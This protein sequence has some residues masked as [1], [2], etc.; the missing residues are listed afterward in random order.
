MSEERTEMSG[1]TLG[2]VLAVALVGVGLIVAIVTTQEESDPVDEAYQQGVDEWFEKRE[3][4]KAVTLAQPKPRELTPT[5]RLYL[6]V[7]A[8]Y[9]EQY[10]IVQRRGDPYEAANT[11]SLIAEGYLQM[12][13]E[14]KYNYWRDVADGHVAEAERQMAEKIGL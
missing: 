13:N 11:A 7:V 6:P 8:Q 1:K 5:E 12:K 4:E 2:I 3:E 9:E 14:A 10:E